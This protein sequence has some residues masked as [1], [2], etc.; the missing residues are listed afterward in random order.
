MIKRY[1][2]QAHASIAFTVEADNEKDAIEKGNEVIAI[3]TEGLSIEVDDAGHW[4]HDLD[5]RAYF[6][7]G[8]LDENDIV[9]DWEVEVN[10]P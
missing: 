8:P 10:N 5:M 4:N 9:D 2:V 3:F 1:R 7:D 6:E